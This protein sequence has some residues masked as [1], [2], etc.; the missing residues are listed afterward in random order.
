MMH[1]L[2]GWMVRCTTP[3]LFLIVGLL[4]HTVPLEVWAKESYIAKHSITK[5]DL[6][7]SPVEPMPSNDHLWI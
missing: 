4:E 3:R 2:W 6:T 5:S 1:Q 7:F